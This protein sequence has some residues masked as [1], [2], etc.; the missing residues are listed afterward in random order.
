M[1]FCQIQNNPCKIKLLCL[2]SLSC[3]GNIFFI[4]DI[5]FLIYHYAHPSPTNQT[6]QASI[7][8]EDESSG[9]V[10]LFQHHSKPAG[11]FQLA[12]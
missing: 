2:E 11:G 5:S 3:F 6:R 9:F 4:F 10:F 8:V 1:P 7:E 12:L